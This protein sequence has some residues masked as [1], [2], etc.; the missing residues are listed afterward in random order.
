MEFLPERWLHQKDYKNSLDIDKWN[1]LQTKQNKNPL[2][3][4]PF[5]FG[6]R[7]CIGKSLA[8]YEIYIALAKVRII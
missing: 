1:E 2:L 3:V 8:E 6:P 5:G 4:L 7:I